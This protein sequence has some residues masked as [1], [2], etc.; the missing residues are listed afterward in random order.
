MSFIGKN[1]TTKNIIKGV[2]DAR[3]VVAGLGRKGQIGLAVGSLA[4]I[5]AV[6]NRS[7]KKRRR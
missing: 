2:E 3:G 4:T 5:G 1:S 7:L 6:S